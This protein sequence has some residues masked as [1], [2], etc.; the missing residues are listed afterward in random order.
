MKVVSFT[1]DEK[2]LEQLD[3]YVIKNNI[4]RTDAIRKAIELLLKEDG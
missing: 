4:T 2:M 1:L 3:R